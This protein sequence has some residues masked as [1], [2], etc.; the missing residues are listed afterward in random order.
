MD[1]DLDK[2]HNWA[3]RWLV[4]FNPQKTEEMLFSRKLQ[5][6][7]H[8]KLT[9]DNIEIQRVPFHKHLGI[10]FNSDCSW[11]EHIISIRPHQFD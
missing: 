7:N 9:M 4:K 5:K 3:N 6:V 10:I 11:H 2:I 8:P 1:N